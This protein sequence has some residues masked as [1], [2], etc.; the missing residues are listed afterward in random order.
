MEWSQSSP[1]VVHAT[2]DVNTWRAQTPDVDV[3]RPGR[4][5]RCG[6][7][8]RPLGGPLGMV[9]HGLRRRQV[10]GPSRAGAEPEMV[11]LDV[12]RYRCRSCEHTVTVV[13]R[14][15]VGRRHYR[16]S[17]IALACW[18]WSFGGLSLGHTRAQVAPGRTDEPGWAAV[19]RWLRAVG[20][21][22]L[23]ASVRASPDGFTPR[24]RAERLAA[25]MM[26]LAPSS[27]GSPQERLFAGAALAA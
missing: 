3:V 12:R 11:E 19:R 7:A 2:V 13:P 10:R 16:A 26:A 5:P 17:A 18:L 24:Q 9:G 8:G 25:T 1:G 22:R 4:C 23:F 21:G 27:S 14:G 15:V 6:A 20:A